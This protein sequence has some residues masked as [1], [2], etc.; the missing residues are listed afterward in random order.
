V[1][2]SGD[3]S[4]RFIS[5]NLVDP[6]VGARLVDGLALEYNMKRIDAFCAG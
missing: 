1:C 6:A 2:E 3:G 4:D 5:L